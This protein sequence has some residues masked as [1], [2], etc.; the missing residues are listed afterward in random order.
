MTSALPGARGPK[1]GGKPGVFDWLYRLWDYFRYG[2]EREYFR[3]YFPAVLEKELLFRP[4]RKYDIPSVAAIEQT[5]YPFPWSEATFHDCFNANYYNWVGEYQGQVAAYGILS[6]VLDESHV[7]NLCVAPA[8][9]KRGFGHQ[10]LRKLIDEARAKG[11]DTL[12]LEARPS[13]V[14]ALRLYYGMGFNEVGLRRDYYPAVGG[15][16]EDA[17]LLALALGEGMN[18]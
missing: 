1:Q 5:A 8:M 10:M 14:S 15:R 13:N 16:R 2:R 12:F 3:T 11:A 17:L 18:G 9:Q 4:M 7:L 6:V